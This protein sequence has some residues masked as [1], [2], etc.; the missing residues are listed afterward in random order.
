MDST[1]Q[2]DLYLSAVL[3]LWDRGLDT[4]QIADTLGDKEQ[5]TERALHAALDRRERLRSHVE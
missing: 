3:A 2:R 4:L 1:T 5:H